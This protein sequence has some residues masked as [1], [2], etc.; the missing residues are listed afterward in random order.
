M[1]LD[2]ILIKNIEQNE[3]ILKN[4]ENE[5]DEIIDASEERLNFQ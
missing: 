1:T 3:D 2:E 4:K 5:I